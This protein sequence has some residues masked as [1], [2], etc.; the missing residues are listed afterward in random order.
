MKKIT[1][2]L[3]VVLCLIMLMSTCSVL[4]IGAQAATTAAPTF[5]FEE[6]AKE[7]NVVTYELKLKSGGFNAID[8]NFT[9]S[10][11]VTCT[12]ITAA[13]SF[14]GA[15]SNPKSA[16]IGY[17][18]TQTFTKTGTIITAK[19]TVPSSGSYDINAVV[20][21]CTISEGENNIDVTGQVTFDNGSVSIFAQIINAIVSFFQAIAK[22]F[23]GLFA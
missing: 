12:G 19:F 6:T 17:A 23:S 9:M 18:N 4:F 5:T 21:S 14:S 1:K 2:V 10:S 11:G 16:S 22:F 15:I 7:G 8:I 13:D 20:S 3:S